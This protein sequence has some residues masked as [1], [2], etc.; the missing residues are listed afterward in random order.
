MHLHAFVQSE[1]NAA[2]QH[3]VARSLREISL[4]YST[5][6]PGDATMLRLPKQ[7]DAFL[8]IA[9]D[10]HRLLPRLPGIHTEHVVVSKFNLP[11]ARADGIM[12]VD[13]GATRLQEAAHL[14]SAASHAMKWF[15]G[16]F[17]RQPS[18]ALLSNGEEAG[19]GAT[20]VNEAHADLREKFGALFH[21]NI[22]PMDLYTDNAPDIVVTDGFTGNIIYQTLRSAPAYLTQVLQSALSRNW[23][24]R[25]GLRLSGHAFAHARQT[26]NYLAYSA[27]LGYDVPCLLYDLA[28]AEQIVED[29]IIQMVRITKKAVIFQSQHQE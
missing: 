22:E 12:L 6:S 4:E 16:M 17:N 24:D 18:L 29:K 19:K 20:L 26:S 9:T 1:Y 15:R 3:V 5:I 25:L 2:L 14:T 7:A 28:D 27:L 10:L 21:G 13:T 23:R 8:C 11:G